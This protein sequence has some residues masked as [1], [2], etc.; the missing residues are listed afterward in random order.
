MP[1]YTLGCHI[2]FFSEYRY[3]QAAQLDEIFDL[4]AA[5]GYPGI[6]IFAPTLERPDWYEATSRALER[7]DLHL[8][9]GSSGGNLAD[10]ANWGSFLASQEAY[11][12]KLT[13]LGTDLK[14]GFTAG[15]KKLAERTP[16]ENEHIVKAWPELCALFRS[17]GLTVNYHTHGEPPEDIQFVI[18]HVPADVLPFGPDLDWLRFGG[19]DPIPFLRAHA[20][21]LVMLH[22]RDYWLG[23]TRTWYLGEGD[24]DYAELARVLD[25]I[26]FTGDA[27]IEPAIPPGSDPATVPIAD[28]LHK[29]RE[30]IREQMGL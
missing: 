15:G 5:C 22:L 4:V 21:R 17:Y 27:V 6:E 26:G 10:A 9:G 2:Y 30:T 12:A 8:I 24:A 28:V 16:E 3:D 23:G 7:N 14:C 25:E 20:D 19:T 29:S 18:D 11:A 1:A 13:R